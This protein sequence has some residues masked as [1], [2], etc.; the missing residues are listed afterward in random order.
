MFLKIRNYFFSGNYSLIQNNQST[1]A[2]LD[3]RSSKNEQM[4]THS[5][6][7]IPEHIFK[8]KMVD[9]FRQRFENDFSFAVR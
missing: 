6:E 3:Q 4:I 5:K 2:I 8:I 9:N 7:H 1:F